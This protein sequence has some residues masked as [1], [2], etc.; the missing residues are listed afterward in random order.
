VAIV[1][2]A[3]GKLG[4]AILQYPVAYQWSKQNGGKKFQLWLDQRMLKPLVNLF[5][6]QDCVESVKLIPG[7]ENYTCGGQ[8]WHF[9]LKTEE[10]LDDVIYHLG[11]RAFPQRQITLQ[12]AMDVPFHL[13]NTKLAE[14]SLFVEPT[15]RAN[16]VLLHG[17]FLSPQTGCPGFWKF[18]NFVRTDLEEMFEEIVFIGTADERTRATEVYPKWKSFDDQGDFL[19]L[20]RYMS[21]S[22]LVIGAGS[23]CVALAGVMGIASVRVHDPIGDFPRVIWSN[24]G[25]KQLNESLPKL[26]AEWPRFKEALSVQPV[27]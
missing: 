10:H 1:F 7:I 17:T 11:F 15:E 13:D 16:R 22:K 2:S 5:A 6:S 24:L 21:G 20:A 12:T 9:N 26:R 18:L 3:P 8:P 27:G 23:C 4:D 25:P 14:P 19:N